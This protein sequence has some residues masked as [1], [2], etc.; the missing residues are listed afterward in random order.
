MYD[1][2]PSDRELVKRLT[3]AKEFLK[4]S[5]GIFANPAKVLGE[6]YDLDIGEA[7]EVWEL[8]RELL[9]EITLKDYSGTRP[10]QKSY[11]KTINGLELVAFCWWSPKLRKKMY[12]KF[13]LKNERYYYVSLHRSK[14][15]EGKNEVPKL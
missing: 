3:E 9:E 7:D 11:E 1:R 2:R 12:I 15:E 10:P 13:A 5:N 6:L 4:K 14:E 8:I